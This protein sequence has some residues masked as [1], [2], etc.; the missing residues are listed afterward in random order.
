[1]G[2]NTERGT[3]GHTCFW[4]SIISCKN[5]EIISDRTSTTPVVI[6]A[7]T[8]RGLAGRIYVSRHSLVNL[9]CEAECR[10]HS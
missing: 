8:K 1:M 7:T 3:E 5:C 9:E 2:C 10:M 6:L 4:E